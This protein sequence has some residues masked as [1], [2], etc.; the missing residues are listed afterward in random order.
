RHA[1]AGRIELRLRCADDAIDLRVADDGVG[2]DTSEVRSRRLG[3][4]TMAERAKAIGGDLRIESAPG[5]G[6]TVNLAVRP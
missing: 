4:T 6:T 3:L 5:V 2:F 1:H